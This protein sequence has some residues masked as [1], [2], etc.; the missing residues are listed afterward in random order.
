MLFVVLEGTWALISLKLII[1]N[2]IKNEKQKFK[3]LGASPRGMNW[4]I[5]LKIRGKPWGI[6]P[7]MRD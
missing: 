2:K 7:S 3:I 6:K 4:K 1:T 5:F